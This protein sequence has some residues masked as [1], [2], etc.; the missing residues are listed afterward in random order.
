ML[1]PWENL[2]NLFNHVDPVIHNYLN[3]ELGIHKLND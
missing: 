3:V 1:S 2:T